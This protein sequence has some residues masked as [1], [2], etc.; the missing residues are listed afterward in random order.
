MPLSI[1]DLLA[2]SYAK[3]LEMVKMTLADFSDAEMLVR[4]VPGAN[5]ANWQLGHLVVSEVHIIGALGAKM[6]ELPAGQ[7]PG[8]ALVGGQRRDG[9][10]C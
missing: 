2:D 10:L 9:V 7:D 1:Q 3:N 5:H 4:P 6:P 8:F